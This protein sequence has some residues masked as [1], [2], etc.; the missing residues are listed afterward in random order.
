MHFLCFQAVFALMSDSLLT[1]QV[2]LHYWASHQSIL[3]T[4]GRICEI[5]AK[6]FRELAILKNGHF[7]KSA[8]LNFFL[9]KKEFFLLNF[10][11]NQSKFV[12]QNGWVEILT[13]SLVSK[14]FLGVRNITLYSVNW[15]CAQNKQ[16][17]DKQ[18]VNYTPCKKAVVNNASYKMQSMYILQTIIEHYQTVRY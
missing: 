14:K 2:E 1:T 12:W 4:Q 17:V 18:S 11:E 6:K 8:I 16:S 13:F 7:E 10:F 3:Q 5:F 9:Q 15:G